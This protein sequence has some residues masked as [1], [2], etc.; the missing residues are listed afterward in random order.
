MLH[1]TVRLLAWAAAVVFSQLLPLAMLVPV[2]AAVTGLAMWRAG[3]HL[4]LLLRRTRWLILA[5]L[6]LFAFATPGVYVLPALGAFGPSEEGMRLGLEHALRL[7]VVLSALALLLQLNDMD[8]L[9]SGLHGLLWPLEWLGLDRGR[10]ALRLMLVLR[11]VEQAPPGQH[12]RAWL[13]GPVGAER[14]GVLSLRRHRLTALD[15]AVLA[16]LTFLLLA[17]ILA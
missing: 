13:E 4:T 10:V 6:L 12:W 15:V 7:L 9:L 17:A 11:Y 5:L 3:R 16:G 2:C 14:I 8:G 1:P